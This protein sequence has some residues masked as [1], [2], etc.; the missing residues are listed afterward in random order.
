MAKQMT[1]C[2]Y[3]GYILVTRGTPVK[4]FVT[5]KGLISLEAYLTNAECYFFLSLDFLCLLQ[6]SLSS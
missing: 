1:L 5:F 4:G 3:V 2:V 6:F